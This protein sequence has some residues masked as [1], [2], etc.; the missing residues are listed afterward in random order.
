MGRLVR[1]Q[2]SAMNDSL[3]REWGR[4]TENRGESPCGA[5]RVEKEGYFLA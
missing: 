3:N 5:R 2:T 1:E 4:A